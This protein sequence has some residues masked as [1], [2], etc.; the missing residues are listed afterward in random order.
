MDFKVWPTFI[1][2]IPRFWDDKK[3][4]FRFGDV[5]ITPTLEVIKDCL[6]SIGTCGKR[7]KMSK[8]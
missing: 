3:M 4:V 2:V 8:S 7:K 6:D 1:E 5:E